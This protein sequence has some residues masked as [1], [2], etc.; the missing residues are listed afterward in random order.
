[1]RHREIFGPLRL[2]DGLFRP[3]SAQSRYLLAMDHDRSTI[4]SRGS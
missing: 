1:V 3:Q 4:R 2:H